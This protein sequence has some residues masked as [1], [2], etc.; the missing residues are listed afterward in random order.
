MKKEESSYFGPKDHYA[1]PNYTDE[2]LFRNTTTYGVNSDATSPAKRDSVNL[3][4]SAR[5]NIIKSIANKIHSKHMNNTNGFSKLGLN[6]NK[7]EEFAKI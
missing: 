4:I 1:S 2:K 6:V 5:K 3:D 7:I